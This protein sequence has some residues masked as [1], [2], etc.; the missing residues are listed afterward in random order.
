MA[1][2]KGPRE[3]IERRFGE[4]VFGKGK[5]LKK[6]N[7][8]PGQHGKR[9][10]NKSFYAK[11]LLEKQK[12]KYIYGI[13]EK[14]FYN[15][16]RKAASSKGMTGEVLLQMLESRLDNVVYRL[17]LAPTRR[18]ARQLVSHRHITLDGK[19]VTIPSFATSVY[20]IIGVKEKSR[21]II[22]NVPTKSNYEWLD[23]DKQ[24]FT[25]RVLAIPARDKIPENIDEQKVVDLYSR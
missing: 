14:Q 20:S 12:A 8:A 17:G 3:K 18:A 11:Q 24:S 15:L 9:K 16:F 23:W 5:A 4:P 13:L 6:R 7:Y 1:L 22:R 21:D 2:Y 25:G 10:K 19:V